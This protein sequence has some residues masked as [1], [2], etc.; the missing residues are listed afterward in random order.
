MARVA[1]VGVGAIGGVLAGLLETAG[2]HEITL[3]TRRPLPALTV[4]TPTGQVRVTAR[5][6]TD[7]AQA[8]AVDWVLVASKGYDA[9]STALWFPALCST[10]APVA[11]LQ[12]G[13]E[14]RERFEKYM[15]PERLLPV[16][17]DCPAERAQDRTVLMR[18]AAT[19]KIED[20]RLG[21][22]FAALFAGSAVEISL[23][24]DFVTALWWKLCM[25]S[26]G[27]LSALALKP[28]GVLC[29]EAMSR[30]ALAMVA[31]CAAVG[32]AEGAHLDESISEEVLEHYRKHPADSV[33]SLLADRLAGRRM[34]W[35]ERNGAIVR[36]GAK[37][38]IPTPLNAMAAAL[39]EAVDG[40][41][42]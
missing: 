10:G 13:V 39:L 34:E 20:T 18:G 42:V 6:V 40:E 15:N 14:H 4:H 19:M 31:E 5:N 26:V 25:N 29:G 23:V 21:R 17:I 30:V 24:D 2:G 36:K 7:P 11:I 28:S 22:D 16:V 3:C 37:H 9:A 8:E 27:A 12:N 32:R 38:G 1:I 41:T 33:N 35:N